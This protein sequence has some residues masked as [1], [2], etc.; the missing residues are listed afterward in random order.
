MA[1]NILNRVNGSK[2]SVVDNTGIKIARTNSISDI[3]KAINGLTYSSGT[4]I[5][6]GI[7]YAYSSFDNSKDNDKYVIIITDATDP[8]KAKLEDMETRGVKVNSILVDITST[9]FGNEESP[10]PNSGK[11]YLMKN[12]SVDTLVNDI[13]KI[14]RDITFTNKFN[15][16]IL[17]DSSKGNFNLEIID[18]ET[19]GTATINKDGTITWNIENIS[20]S[21]SAK[22]KYKLK[23]NKKQTLATYSLY[24]D[25]KTNKET[26]I[27][28]TKDGSEKSLQGKETEP[29]IQICDAYDVVLQAVG[30]DTTIPVE[31]AKINVTGV[32]EKGNIIV[33]KPG[34]VTD[35]EG[36]VTIK[37]ITQLG[38]IRFTIT[39]DVTGLLGYDTTKSVELEVNNK[40]GETG[41]ELTTVYTEDSSL[42]STEEK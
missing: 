37:N 22:L 38:K 4:T 33:N 31:N 5:E 14:V 23:L 17:K 27:K 12:Y 6:K 35:K 29:T 24:E 34:L 25:I 11:V 42:V 18:S 36:K 9:E 19:D 8:A 41:G 7:E 15:E 21:E 39:P 2:V 3:K 20:A 1:T 10:I 16:E 40:Y 30:R 13:N 32:D 26:T 28:Y